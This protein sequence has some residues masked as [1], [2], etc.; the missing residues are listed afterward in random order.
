MTPFIDEGGHVVRP[1]GIEEHAFAGTGMREA[2][3]LGMQH[4]SRTEGETVL[5]ILAV[6]LR[7][8][9]FEDLA[10]SVFLVGKKR[11]TDMFHVNAN[12]VGTTGLQTALN[13]GDVRKLLEYAPMR[14]GFFGLRTLLEIPHAVN[15][16]IPVI[17]GKCPFDRTA[18]LLERTPDEGVVRTLG[19]VVKEL[20]GEVRFSFRGLGNEQETGGVF[21][22]TVNETDG[23][24]VDVYRLRLF[25]VV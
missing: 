7:A 1:S 8:E 24:V 16:A 21:V 10:A 12:L 6:L 18:L 23:R 9:P 5:D 15:R 22:D 2:E 3:R 4:L 17:A 14:D 25:E 19:R 20:F 13:K 11:M